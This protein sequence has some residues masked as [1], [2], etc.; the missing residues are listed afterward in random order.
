[1]KEGFKRINFFKGFFTQAEDWQ[2]AQ[3]YHLEKRRIHVII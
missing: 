2:S 3:E 1:M